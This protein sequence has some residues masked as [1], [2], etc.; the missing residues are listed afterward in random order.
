MNRISVTFALATL[1]CGPACAQS[2]LNSPSSAQTQATQGTT[3]Q[4]LPQRIQQKLAAQGFTDI[5]VVP[6][7]YIVTA[8]DK[9]GDPVTMVIGPNS[10]A[11][12]LYPRRKSNLQAANLLALGQ[13]TSID[14]K[15]AK[16]SKSGASEGAAPF[17]RCIRHKST[18]G[19]DEA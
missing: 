12:S 8:K 13:R 14:R 4:P 10:I 2:A 11:I 19:R 6:E 5:K 9:D 16:A 7:G 3:R 1:I 17:Y 15:H 18:T